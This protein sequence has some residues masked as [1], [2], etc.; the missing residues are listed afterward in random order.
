MTF[1]PEGELNNFWPI[2]IILI[3]TRIEKITAAVILVP[4]DLI[5]I[6]ILE[7]MA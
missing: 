1:G 6:N 3:S 4:D 5:N 7:V 2:F